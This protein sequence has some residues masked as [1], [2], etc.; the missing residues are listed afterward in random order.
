MFKLTEASIRSD[1]TDLENEGLIH[2]FHGGARIVAP[3]SFE[4][5]RSVN[6]ANKKKIVQKALTHIQEGETLYLDSGTT[7]LLL[8]QELSRVGDLTVVINSPSIL[9]Y[10]GSET[11]KKVIMVGGEWSHEDQCCYGLMTERDLADIYVSKVFMGADSID[12]ETGS[13]FAHLRNLSYISRI[14]KNAK[15]TVLLAD[16]SKFNRIRG[17]KIIDLSDI[18]V[19]ITDEGLPLE[20]QEKIRSLGITL[21]LGE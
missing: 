15:Q 14:I 13:V 6:L 19:I 3:P 9:N 4:T 10:L 5:R 7:V 20:Q 21:E 12:V 1:L 17:M 18:N 16:S 8:A 11:E 2:R